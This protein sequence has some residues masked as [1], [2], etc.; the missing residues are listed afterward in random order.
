MYNKHFPIFLDPSKIFQSGGFFSWM[1]TEDDKNSSRHIIQV[2]Q[3][4][5][6]LPNKDYYLKNDTDSKKVYDSLFF[7]IRQIALGAPYP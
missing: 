5:L 1:V 4:G 6:T 2:D 7:K 3:G